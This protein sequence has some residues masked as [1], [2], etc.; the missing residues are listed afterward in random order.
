MYCRQKSYTGNLDGA[1]VGLIAALKSYLN[2]LLFTPH[3]AIGSLY[4]TEINQVIMKHAPPFRPV[5]LRGL[6]Q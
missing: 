4:L 6:T 2:L 5:N 3:L 1:E